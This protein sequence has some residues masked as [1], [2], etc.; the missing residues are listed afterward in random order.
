MAKQKVCAVVGVGPGNGESLARRFSKDGYAVALL[1]RSLDFTKKLADE[2]PN[3]RAYACDVAEVESVKT[4]FAAIA[5]DLGEVDVL[6]YN[7]GSGVFGDFD[8]VS[9]D[10]LENSW[11]VNT[12]GLFLVAKE[13]VPAMK[14]KKSGAIVVTGATATRRGVPRTVAFA[15]AK[16]AQRLLC[17]SLAR[18]FWPHGIHVALIVLDGMVDLPRTREF[19]KDK[20]DEFFVKPDSVADLAAMLVAQDRSAWTFEAEARP[21][22]ENW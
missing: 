11:K 5:K 21:F 7:A 22:G 3:A 1:A 4:A 17:E 16:G 9:A 15:Q 10:D 14:A 2:L 19:M 13:V 8:S 20:P 18:Q 12:L 6:L